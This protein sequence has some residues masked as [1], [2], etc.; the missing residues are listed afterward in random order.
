MVGAC[1]PGPAKEGTH[2]GAAAAY[3]RALY[4]KGLWHPIIYKGPCAL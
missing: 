2:K 1:G 3:F 4:E